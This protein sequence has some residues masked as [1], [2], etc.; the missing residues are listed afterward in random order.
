MPKRRRG[1]PGAGRKPHFHGL[2]REL[3]GPGILIVAR[4]KS[5]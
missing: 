1:L 3:T 2:T 5:A 4:L